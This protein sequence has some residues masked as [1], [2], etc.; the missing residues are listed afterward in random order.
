[1]RGRGT[2]VYGRELLGDFWGYIADATKIPAPSID[3]KPITTAST[4]PMV[5]RN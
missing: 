2:Y 4:K 3:P 5:R 1:M